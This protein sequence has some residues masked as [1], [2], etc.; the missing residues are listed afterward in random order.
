MV[1]ATSR[2]TSQSPGRIRIEK[3]NLGDLSNSTIP[4]PSVDIGNAASAILFGGATAPRI[5]V[6]SIGG[7]ATPADPRAQIE[8]AADVVLPQVGLTTVVLTGENVPTSWQV[9]LRVTRALGDATIV[10]VTVPPSGNN[11]LWT[12]TLQVDLSSGFSVLQAYANP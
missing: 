12:R 8:S 3:N 2:S 11:T 10:P 9:F 4:P 7:A 5:S 1:V 6:T